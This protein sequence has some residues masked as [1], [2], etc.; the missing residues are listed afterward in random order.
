MIGRETACFAVIGY[1]TF[2]DYSGGLRIMISFDPES[3]SNR[4]KATTVFENQLFTTSS[5]AHATHARHKLEW[6]HFMSAYGIF[7]W[8]LN[9]KQIGQKSACNFEP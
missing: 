8:V 5:E 1:N 6:L 7:S 9:C 3:K 4:L 2:R